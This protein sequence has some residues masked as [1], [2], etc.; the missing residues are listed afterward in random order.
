MT[1]EELSRGIQEIDADLVAEAAFDAHTPESGRAEE[2]TRILVARKRRSGLRAV[3]GFEV[4]ETW[5]EGALT[6]AVIRSQKGQPLPVAYPAIADYE[7]STDDGQKVEVQVLS[8]DRILIPS[9]A[10]GTTYTFQKKDESGISLVSNKKGG[11]SLWYDLNGRLVSDNASHLSQGV[12]VTKG[13]KV[14]FR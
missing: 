4:D 8:P 6:Q 9:T 10:A 5:E 11:N 3:G 7:L 14:A 1:K 13:R 2:P 12:Y